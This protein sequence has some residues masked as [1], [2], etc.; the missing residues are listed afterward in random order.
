LDW[1]DENFPLPQFREMNQDVLDYLETFYTP[2]NPIVEDFMQFTQRF[3]VYSD[4][5][6]IWLGTSV[7][8]LVN[9]G[10]RRVDCELFAAMCTLDISHTLECIRQGGD[11]T[12]RMEAAENAQLNIGDRNFIE[13]LDDRTCGIDFFEVKNYWRFGLFGTPFQSEDDDLWNL[14]RG[15]A[16]IILEAAIRKEFPNLDITPSYY[17]LQEEN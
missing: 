12:I 17:K 9:V 8:E 4:E 6:E 3:V 2:V 16:F 1:Q 14:F 7:E 5:V 10:Y 11:V 15:A 13:F